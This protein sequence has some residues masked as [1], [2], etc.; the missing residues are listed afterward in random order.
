MFPHLGR[1]TVRESLVQGGVLEPL[2]REAQSSKTEAS[3]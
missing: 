3:P 1:V 2:V